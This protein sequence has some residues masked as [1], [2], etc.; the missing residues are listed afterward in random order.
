MSVR[1]FTWVAL[2][3]VSLPFAATL[4]LGV[5]AAGFG[6]F[7]LSQLS[8]AQRDR[9]P[10]ALASAVSALSRSARVA[11]W[12]ATGWG[13]GEPVIESA[14]RAAAVGRALGQLADAGAAAAPAL[15]EALGFEGTRRYLFATLNEAELVG[16][17]GAPLNGLV[18]QL[19]RGV[20]SIPVSGSVSRALNPGNAPYPWE[21]RAGEPWY[22][23]GKDYPLAN[24]TFHPDFTLSGLNLVTAWNGLDLPKVDGVVAVDVSAVSAVLRITGPIATRGYGHVTADNVARVLLVD[25]YRIYPDWPVESALARQA[26]N[27][28]LQSALIERLKDPSTALRAA[29]ALWEVLPSRHVQMYLADPALQSAV[30]DLGAAGS[31]ARPSGDSLGVFLQSAPSKIAIF[32]QV[33]IRRDVE[34]HH[35]GSARVRQLV[36]CTNAIPDDLEGDEEATHGRLALTYRSRVAYRIPLAATRAEVRAVG[37]KALVPADGTGP[38]PDSVGAQVLWQGQDVPPRQ[39]GRT[40][41]SYD[42]PSGTFGEDG[43]FQYMLAAD[44]QPISQP[45]VLEL[46]VSFPV[47]STPRGGQDGWMVEGSTATWTGSLDQPLALSATG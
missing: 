46:T 4:W 12:I 20:P 16:S 30:A 31:L 14:G 17:G 9:S 13:Q 7:G 33:R 22:R 5:A 3:L 11:G 37:R 39:T 36:T 42:L 27:A 25:A 8:F 18:V 32:Q 21:V 34:I 1:R 40:E 44:P 29:R 41:I 43:E 28:E 47:D 35:D 45:P 24:S 10:E 26:A 23:A 19:D 6:A 2:L 15:P 38:F